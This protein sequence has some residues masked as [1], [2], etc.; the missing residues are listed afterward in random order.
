MTE[1]TLFMKHDAILDL[2]AGMAQVLRNRLRDRQLH[3][4]A[5]IGI[6]TG[7]AWV[8][9][10]LGRLLDLQEPSGLLDISFYRDDFTQIGVHPQVKP[11]KIDFDV[12]NRNIVL[13]DDVLHTG[14]TIRAAMNEIFDF[15]RPATITLVTLI[16]RSGR[17][18]P[19]QP[20]VIG[21]SPPLGLD[22]HVKL[23]GPD[24]LSLEILHGARAGRETRR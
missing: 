6:H 23:N 8:A 12:D 22:D 15:G 24:P 13:V 2:I 7:G 14:R 20:D 19:I 3:N 5:I 1:S 16:E 10:H 11:S 17:E 21:L 9:Q 4:P 18:L